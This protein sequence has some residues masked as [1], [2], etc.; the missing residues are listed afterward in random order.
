MG[1]A[2]VSFDQVVDYYYVDLAA[3]EDAERQAAAPANDDGFEEWQDAPQ[4][5]R[6]RGLKGPVFRPCPRPRPRPRPGQGPRRG[7]GIG[8]PIIRP[9]KQNIAQVLKTQGVDKI[10]VVDKLPAGAQK[11]NIKYKGSDTSQTSYRGSQT[12]QTSLDLT[13][14][15]PALNNPTKS[16]AQ[17]QNNQNNI[18][19]LVPLASSTPLKTFGISS[20]PDLRQIQRLGSRDLTLASP[21]SSQS[22]LAS[23]PLQVST[24]RN[25]NAKGASALAPH[26]GKALKKEVRR[27]EK[28][29]KDLDTS[30]ASS[31]KNSQFLKGPRRWTVR[32]PPVKTGGQYNKLNQP[33]GVRARLKKLMRTRKHLRVR[34]GR[35]PLAS[36]HHTR[37]ERT[38]M[39]EAL[40]ANHATFFRPEQPWNRGFKPDYSPASRS[41]I[42][43]A[44]T[45]MTNFFTYGGRGRY[46]G[47]WSMNFLSSFGTMALAGI[48]QSAYTNSVW[49]PRAE[50]ATQAL[51]ENVNTLPWT[52]VRDRSMNETYI[53]PGNGSS[54]AENE[55]LGTT[56]AKPNYF[57]LDQNQTHRQ[58]RRS[59]DML[60]SLPPNPDF[61][62]TIKQWVDEHDSEEQ[63]RQDKAGRREKTPGWLDGIE[64]P[65]VEDFVAMSN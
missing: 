8:R 51:V 64:N 9:T 2:F 40:M 21:R 55:E 17:V 26:K 23:A 65:T 20:Q 44:A 15:G 41:F 38:A 27:A 50:A 39:Q 43:Q 46:L 49:G 56:T 47:K 19:P 57:G 28:A 31:S 16:F 1:E 33:A 36:A 6:K 62:H 30:V 52:I 45:G 48:V 37:A 29:Q 34:V 13:L 10:K 59:L 5:W 60:E 54:S 58:F 24:Y 12:L 53:V 61:E 14:N 32:H 63:K 4:R 22:S 3:E 7:T 25:P 42:S 18:F 35:S 11:I